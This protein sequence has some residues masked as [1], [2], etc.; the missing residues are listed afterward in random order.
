MSDAAN[1]ETSRNS[2]FPFIT[3]GA[4]VGVLFAFLFLMWLAASKENPLAQP[5]PDVTEAKDEP[6]L[7]AAAKLAE[8]QARNEAALKG[9]GAKMSRDEAHGKL[10][11]T[12]KGPNDKL[13]FPTP[14]PPTPV[15]KKDEKKDDKEKGKEKP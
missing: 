12:L 11:G 9:V 8:V 10:M 1:N 15:V 5:K 6:K 13:P 4:A 2:G 14:E 3:V 7:D